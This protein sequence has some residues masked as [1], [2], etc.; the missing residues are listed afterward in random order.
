MKYKLVATDL[1]GTFLDSDSN[2]SQKNIDTV[3]TLTDS[4]CIF[5]I[6]TGRMYCSVKPYLEQL[7]N[8]ELVGLYQGGIIMDAFNGNVMYKTT[9]KNS[10]AQKIYSDAVRLGLNVQAYTDDVYIENYDEYTQLYEKMTR[11]KATLVD[12]LDDIINK[13][14]LLKLLINTSEGKVKQY[15]DY[16]M[17]KYSNDVSVVSSGKHFIEFTHPDANKGHALEIIAKRYGVD[18]KEIIAFG[19]HYND[20]P[21]L[22]F[23]GMGV[24]MGNAVQK[25][26]DS[27]DFVTL[28]NDE[29]GFAY[30]INKIL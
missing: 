4:G 5:V 24:A 29:D 13:G 26:K 14:E 7:N 19:D 17:H 9:M 11:S 20:I 10:I 18:R 28:S 25:L 21:M 3:N 6:I 2:I 16:F 22:K 12:S 30:A 15:Y 27:A 8:K 23:A 1:D